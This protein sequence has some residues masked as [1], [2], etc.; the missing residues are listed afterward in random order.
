MERVYPVP[1]CLLPAPELKGNGRFQQPT[2]DIKHSTH[3]GF[4]SDWMKEGKL[5]MNRKRN[6]E[7]GFSLLESLIVI[8]IMM[9][10][11]GFAFLKT[12]GTVQEYKSN[13]ALDVISSQLRIARGLAISQRRDVALTF[14]TTNQTVSY[15]VL[16]PTTVGTTEVNGPV[17]TMRLPNQTQFVV[18]SGVPDTPMAFG[19][20][21]GASPIC[22]G[23]VGGGPAIM[24]F[25]STG[26][27][28]D[29]TDYNVQNGTIFIGM[30]NKVATARAVTI[31]G[32][33]GRVRPYRWIGAGSSSS[34]YWVE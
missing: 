27:F 21:S 26:Q 22:I 13:A 16:A 32:G 6:R 9:I 34:Q 11:A 5:P 28:T 19:A 25:T 15:Q 30:P 33:T 1:N 8:G 14:D 23:G 29:G 31:M 17:V 10:M 12:T 3:R 20:C 18:E 2:G 24:H 7:D 4:L